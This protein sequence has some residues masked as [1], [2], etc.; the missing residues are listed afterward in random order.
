MAPVTG[1]KSLSRSAKESAFETEDSAPPKRSRASSSSAGKT[2]AETVTQDPR[3]KNT[4]T[5]T[6]VKN[7]SLDSVK[8][9]IELRKGQPIPT[10]LET[11]VRW[12]I[13]MIAL[14]KQIQ[15]TNKLAH[16]NASENV[17]RVV[18]HF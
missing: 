14:V 18:F 6:S 2:K 9:Y 17:N 16:Q 13:Y 7:V 4:L 1:K 8:R 5:F 3:R 12:F 10:N 11:L 15:H